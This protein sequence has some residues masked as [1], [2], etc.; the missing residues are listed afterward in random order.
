M[1]RVALSEVPSEAVIEINSSCSIKNFFF[2]KNLHVLTFYRRQAVPFM[3][4][5]YANP[6]LFYPGCREYDNVFSLSI[7][8]FLFTHT[9]FSRDNH[10][11]TSADEKIAQRFTN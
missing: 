5:R 7:Y 2:Q 6:K 1:F 9:L 10:Q 8:D 3:M 11:N 4:C